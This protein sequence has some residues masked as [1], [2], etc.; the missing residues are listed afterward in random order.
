[1]SEVRRARVCRRGLFFSSLLMLAAA[2]LVAPH[3][4]DSAELVRMRN[5][6]LLDARESRFDWTP[7]TRPNDFAQETGPIDPAFAHRVAALPIDPS[8]ADWER[9]LVIA[10]HLLENRQGSVGGAIQSDLESTYV[11][12]RGTGGGYCG[13]FADVFTAMAL[14]AGLDVRSWAFSFDGFGGRGH[15]FNEVWDGE[16]GQWRMIDV[17][18]NYY[19]T[20]RDGGVLSAQAFRDHMRSDPD[21]VQLQIIEPAAKLVFVR[22]DRARDFYHRGLDEWYLW[23]G[24]NV[25]TYD[26]AG[27]VRTLGRMS[28]SLE[29]IGGIVQGVHPQIRV[30]PDPANRRQLEALQGLGKRLWLALIL[31]VVGVSGAVTCAVGW[32]RARKVREG[33]V[34]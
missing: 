15:I 11:E 25:F 27:L 19:M 1:M 20:D 31:G 13:D 28:P 5:A 18:H 23:W 24:N 30:L 6:L 10:R 3:L 17:F 2:T 32:K 34:A 9:A 8:S 22:E 7:A 14:A 21:E 16:S 4:T 12:I 29:Q 26:R 33:G